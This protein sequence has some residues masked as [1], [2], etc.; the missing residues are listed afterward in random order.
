MTPLYVV[1]ATIMIV[2]IQ[3]LV[4]IY[5]IYHSKCRIINGNK[6]VVHFVVVEETKVA[7]VFFYT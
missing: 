5:N 3:L 2:Y 6:N 4:Y 7:L 1:L